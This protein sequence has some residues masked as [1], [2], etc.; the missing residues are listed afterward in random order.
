M[1]NNQ[2]ENDS[3]AYT[4]DHSGTKTTVEVFMFSN[5]NIQ[6]SV[7]NIVTV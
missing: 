7:D 2:L 6:T 3:A 5:L 4:E 1:T